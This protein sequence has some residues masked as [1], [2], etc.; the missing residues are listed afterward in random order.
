MNRYEKAEL[1][2]RYWC[3]GKG[4]V[5]TLKAMEF[6]KEKHNGYRK[7]GKTLEFYHQLCICQY[8][9][10]LPGLLDMER[11]LTDGLLHDT[12]EDKD[13]TLKE[14]SDLFGADIALD[15]GLLSKEVEGVKKPLAL[16][17]S[18]IETNAHTSIVKGADRVHNH[19]SMVGVFT[20]PKELSYIA[21]TEND[22]L[23]ML[24][25][26]RRSFP[27][28]EA[29]YENI[30]YML[31]CQIELVRAIHEAKNGDAVEIG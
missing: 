2:F 8:I 19:Q 16:Y 6:G 3:I 20:F 15:M 28:Q 11:C 25:A 4:Y 18:Q 9:R 10:T 21:E 31:N 24:K 13:V 17:F 14:I 29:A 26:A 1:T 30:K 27:E 5:R 22:I 12:V 23:P 7:D